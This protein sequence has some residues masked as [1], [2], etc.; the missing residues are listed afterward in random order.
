[1]STII[2]APQNA[3][4]R[5]R[6]ILDS[7]LIAS[8]SLDSRLK[9]GDPGLLCKLD[10]EKAYDH[11]SWDF[12]LYMLRRCGFGQKWCS[13]IAFCIS[14]A[15]FSILINGSP[16]GFFNSSR[17]VR[18]GDPISP[19]LFVIV[20]EAFSR[21]VKASVD[22]GLFSG[23]VVG[24]R[25]SVQAHISHLL[26]ADDTLVFS[27]ASQ[28]QVQAI[29]DLLICFE[30]V[31]GLKVNLAKSV[32][33]PV[34]EVS[35]M[36]ALAEILGCEVGSFPITYL[37]MPLGARFKDKACWNG[38]VEKTMRS[39]ASWKRSYLSKGGRIA[40]IKSTLSNLPTYLLSLL[41]IPLA[42]AKHIES[43][44]S[45]FL[46]GGMGE[47]FKFHLVNWRKVCSP[48]REGGLGIRS[49]RSFNHALLGKWLWRY[50][51]EPGAS[52][53]KVV[54]AKYGSERGGWRSKIGAGS[55]GR[56]LWK[57][58]SKEWYHFFSHIRLIPGDGSRISFWGEVWC[59]NLPLLE[60][61]PGLY[62][63]ASNKEASIADNLELVSGY[64][65]WNI[66][67]LR[68]LNDWEVDE[69]ASLYS[70]LYSYN[71]G[72]GADKIWWIP[73]R[74]G[75]FEV[76][77]FYTILTSSV[78]IHF[79]WKSIWRT[80]A[81]PRVAFFVWSAALGKILT[82][83]NLRKK[84]LVLVNRCGMCKKEEESIDHLLLHCES[85]Q[86]L[87]SAFF[88]RFGLAW[89][90]PRGVVDLMHC[91]WSGGRPR[92]AVAWKMVPHCIMWCIWSE[93]NERFFED[94]ERSLEDLL[95]FFFSTLFT[96]TAAWLDPIVITFSDFISLFSSPL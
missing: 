26:F 25:G 48:V 47:E 3:F 18:Q 70:L 68:S 4:V 9:S 61:F 94:S 2:S 81:P 16:A 31:S 78:N 77:S 21:M 85:A 19:F 44:Q 65:Q 14:T 39:L 12:L 24:N 73:N 74:R 84:N 91:W 43:I 60:L 41:P 80:K 79:P 30:L 22:H 13:W 45:G 23:F 11:V 46:W 57:F 35:D 75:K 95:H 67:F 53:R 8:E 36:G 29:R 56:G 28:V 52:W 92:S 6:Q 42:V 50:A 76:R 88:R 5:G 15:S 40:L 1:M 63:L 20:M 86:F 89:V 83:D 51:T 54:E 72:D 82:L 93:R 34:G 7:V 17:G 55:H 32:L 27:E 37:G 59:G 87:W 10:M 33:V 69:L 58:I 96:W 64:R 62:G 71:L 38:V 90:M 49:L 66:S